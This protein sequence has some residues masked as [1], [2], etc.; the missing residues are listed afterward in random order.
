MT[1]PYAIETDVPIPTPRVTGVAPVIRAL[2]ASKVG[3]SVFF[4]D[5]ARRALMGSV[6]RLL[7]KG[8]FTVRKVDGGFRVWKTAEPQPEAAE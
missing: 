6:Q 2:A 8:N 5:T 4:P 7:G 3:A 1:K